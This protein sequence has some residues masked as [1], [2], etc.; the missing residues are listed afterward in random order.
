MGKVP[1][2]VHCSHQDNAG[3]LAGPR[4]RLDQPFVRSSSEFRFERSVPSFAAGNHVELAHQHRADA[5]PD[6]HDIFDGLRRRLRL[7]NLSINFD[8]QLSHHHV[9]VRHRKG[10]CRQL[11]TEQP[12]LRPLS[13]YDVSDWLQCCWAAR[14]GMEQH[15]ERVCS[16][17]GSTHEF[18]Q[19]TPN[20]LLQLMQ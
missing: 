16:G 8:Q 5:V 17:R 3:N 1:T 12:R 4:P 11:G 13:L 14:E 19:M 10:V 15:N 7:L 18:L 2:P 20:K 6:E 9:G